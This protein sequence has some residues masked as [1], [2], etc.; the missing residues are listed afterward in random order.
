MFLQQIN[1]VS[2]Q[3]ELVHIPSEGDP[4]S[5]CPCS[6]HDHEPQLHHACH[7]GWAVLMAMPFLDI[8]R[9]DVHTIM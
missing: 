7:A 9:T 4:H 1:P 8:H 2:G 5:Q 3:L 6:L